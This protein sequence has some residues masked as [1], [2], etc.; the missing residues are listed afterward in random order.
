MNAATAKNLSITCFGLAAVIALLWI[1]GGLGGPNPV[2]VPQQAYQPITSRNGMQI[3]VGPDWSPAI[4]IPGDAC[5]WLDS[6]APGLEMETSQDGGRTWGKHARSTHVRF[7]SPTHS[8]ATFT[9]HAPPPD[10]SP[11]KRIY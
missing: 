8:T 5:F 9:V 10:G 6:P 7:R 4:A 1:T 3:A 11:Y 2:A